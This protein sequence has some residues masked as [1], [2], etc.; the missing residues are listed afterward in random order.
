MS[1]KA[2]LP[3]QLCTHIRMW[4]DGRPRGRVD[5]MGLLTSL[6]VTKDHHSPSWTT[7]RVFLPGSKKKKSS[8]RAS[9]HAALCCRPPSRA[10]LP[11]PGRQREP[12]HKQQPR[13]PHVVPA[14][15]RC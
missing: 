7:F 8:S 2:M 3:L 12:G 10:R 5:G 11:S 6:S 4:Q 9:S 15:L 14:C 1:Q 13:Q